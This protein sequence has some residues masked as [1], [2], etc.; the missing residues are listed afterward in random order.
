MLFHLS[1]SGKSAVERERAVADLG[2]RSRLLRSYLTRTVLDELEPQR[3]EFL[4]AT[5]TLG[6]LTGPLCDELLDREGS[7]VLEELASRQFFTTLAED[8]RSYRYHQ[9]LQTLLEGLLVEERGPRT[10]ASCMPAAASARGGGMP[11]EALRAYA[12]AEDFASVARMLQQSTAGLAMDQRVAVDGARDDP[13]LALVRA[14]RLQRSGSCAAAVAAF[15]E[16]ETLLDDSEFRRRCGEERAAARVWLADATIT[17]LAVPGQPVLA[18][19]PRRSGQ[20]RRIPPP[21]RLP[22]HPLAEGIGLL[23]AGEASQASRTL[24]HLVPAS[25]PEQ[26]FAD[27]ARVVA[28]LVSGGRRLCRHLERIIL[29]AEVEE[30]P[31]VARAA[32]GLQAAV[33]LVT[34]PEPWRTE[35]CESLVDEC[36]RSGDEWGA[37]LLAGAL[38]VAHAVRREPDAEL[39]LDRSA[40]GARI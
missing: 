21:D 24:A 35:S 26:L 29:T 7:A 5:C 38:G 40:A 18:A 37:M 4:L 31:W 8:G 14:R 17:D 32:R 13:W 16:A 33:L 11:S 6:T 28:E 2:G 34:S 10:A 15:G 3:R 22:S 39:W 12:M 27:L 25:I 30:Q 23:L 9:V 20:R 36:E 1:T 19:S